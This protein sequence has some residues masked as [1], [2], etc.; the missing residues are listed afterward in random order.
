MKKI[1]VYC[2]ELSRLQL[3]LPLPESWSPGPRALLPWLWLLGTPRYQR[4]GGLG[5]GPGNVVT[6][7]RK[8][9]LAL[10]LDCTIA[11]VSEEIYSKWVGA[12]HSLQT[13]AI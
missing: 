7:P 12:P 11:N 13:P 8:S 4:D 3:P 10:K 5:G 9:G 1:I 6:F 2:F